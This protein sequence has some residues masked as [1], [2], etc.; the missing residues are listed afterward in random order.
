MALQRE[1]QRELLLMNPSMVQM[2]THTTIRMLTLT[3]MTHNRLNGLPILMPKWIE[4]QKTGKTTNTVA[5]DPVVEL[6][7][8][9]QPIAVDSFK[10]VCLSALHC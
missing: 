9:K 3:M 5:P 4:R 7:H 8:V 2:V 1:H 10:V 6:G